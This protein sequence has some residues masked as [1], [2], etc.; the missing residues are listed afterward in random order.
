M[1]V[2]Q[3]VL[4]ASV[5]IKF[6]LEEEFSNEVDAIFARA[7]LSASPEIAF[8]VPDLFF[9]ECANILWKAVRRGEHDARQARA[10]VDDLQRM[11]IASTSMTLLIGKAIEI[12]CVYGTT[13]YD[14]C[15]VALAE[16]LNV[17]LLTADVKLA[18]QL[19]GSPF[20]LL[21]LDTYVTLFHS[22]D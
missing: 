21:R 7:F 10:D 18:N 9:A 12:A 4:D 15:Y 13:A 1:S 19:H 17:P 14:A 22:T 20:N 6:F 16:R 8:H 11:A 2:Q 5:A 3:Y